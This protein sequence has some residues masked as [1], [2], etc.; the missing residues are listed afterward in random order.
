MSELAELWIAVEDHQVVVVGIDADVAPAA[1][2]VAV[3]LGVSKLVITDPEG[4]WGPSFAS[5]EDLGDDGSPRPIVAGAI[6]RALAGGVDG[7]NLCRFEDLDT[8]LFTFD[9]AGTLFTADAYLSVSP[10]VADDFPVVEGLVQR[11]VAEGYLRPRSRAE[12]IRLALGGLGARV[13]PSG[14]LAGFGTLERERYAGERLAEVACL[15]AI[16]R[17]SGEGVGAELVD[18]LVAQARGLGS[19]AVFACT[20]SER[21]A[22]LF[23]RCGFGEVGLDRLPEQKWVDYDPERRRRLRALWLDLGS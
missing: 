18:G 6:R 7:V 14:H 8:E 20:V 10:L 1:A 22:G 5:E 17:F 4:G 23:V 9:G 21:A 2:D 16:N 11:G 3:R 13:S 15:Y 12:T 19:R